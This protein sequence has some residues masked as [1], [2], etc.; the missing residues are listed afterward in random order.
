M[1]RTGL[2]GKERYSKNLETKSSPH[3]KEN[4]GCAMSFL[5]FRYRNFK[6]TYQSLKNTS[7]IIID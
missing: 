2:R 3:K 1:A 4:F 6:K 7:V 5:F